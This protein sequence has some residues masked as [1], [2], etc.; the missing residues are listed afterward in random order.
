MTTQP[1]MWEAEAAKIAKTNM[2]RKYLQKKNMV[3]RCSPGQ[4][5]IN[6]C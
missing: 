4:L 1:V 5:V 6:Q 3:V 2:F